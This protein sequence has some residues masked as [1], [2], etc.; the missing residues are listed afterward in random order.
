MYNL[1][2]DLSDRNDAIKV[3]DDAIE[4]SLRDLA[5]LILHT[6][7]LAVFPIQLKEPENCF[8]KTISMTDFLQVTVSDAVEVIRQKKKSQSDM[9]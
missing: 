3:N 7:D 1:Q 5:E 4:V 6:I 8:L 2:I 9:A